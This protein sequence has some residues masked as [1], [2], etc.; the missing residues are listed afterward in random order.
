MKRFKFTPVLGWSISRYTLFETCKRQYYYTYYPKYDPDQSPE[1]ILALKRMTSIPLEIGNIV[2]DV[3]KTLLERLQK[4]ASPI[5]RKR[6]FDYAKE[7]TR[8]YV[9]SKTFQEVYYGKIKIVHIE[10]VFERVWKSLDNLLKSDR[11]SWLLDCALSSKDHWLIE[12]PGYGETRINGKKA[13]CKVDFMFPVKNRCFI[14]DWKTGKP[15]DK[16]H[17]RQM[18]AYTAWAAYHFDTAPNTISPIVAYLHPKY[19]ETR[20]K[21]TETDISAFED[22]VAGETERMQQY[23]RNIKQNIPKDKALFKPHKSKLCDY[24]NFREICK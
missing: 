24:C 6:F 8:Q 13:Y 3:N 5:D 17:R 19:R 10:D 4:T 14:M 23:C 16:K 2:H 18:L 20:I 11:F 21:V 22:Q 9:E 12:P 1:K 7:K 15:D